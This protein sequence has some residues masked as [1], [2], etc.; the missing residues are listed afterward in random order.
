MPAPPAPWNAN[1]ATPKPA[2]S[3]GY[4]PESFKVDKPQTVQGQVTDII[5]KD[6][7][8]MQQAKT[9]AAQYANAR[10]LINSSMAAGAAQGAV[11]EAALPIAQQDASTYNNAMT[12]T[13]NAE[14][15]ARNFDAAGRNAASGQNAQLGTSVHLANQD[16][17]NKSLEAAFNAQTNYGLA[18]LDAN[19]KVALQHLD[20]ANKITLMNLENANRQSLQANQ[21]AASMFNQ[22]VTAIANISQ[23]PNLSPAAKDAAINSQLSLLSEGLRQQGNVAR[24]DLGSY[25]QQGSVGT[26]GD[27]VNFSNLPLMGSVPTGGRRDEVGHVFN[28]DGTPVTDYRGPVG[29]P[30]NNAGGGSQGGDGSQTPRPIAPTGTVTNPSAPPNQNS[31]TIQPVNP[32]NWKPGMPPP[33]GYKLTNRGQLVKAYPMLTLERTMT[34][35]PLTVDEIYLCVDYGYQFH[36]EKQ[37]PGDFNAEV[38]MRN[39]TIFMNSGLGAILG[40]WNGDELVGGLG[41]YLSPDITTGQMTANEFF[42]FVRE[43]ERKGSWPLRLVHA[44]KA[45]GKAHG[46]VRFRM[47]HLL[48]PNESVA[49]VRLAYFYRRLGMRPI[50]VGYEGEL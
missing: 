27:P 40:L 2:D 6:S 34:I 50:E 32:A 41:C 43:G 38:F 3:F 8:L 46:A 25:F 26:I 49:T 39:W 35:R 12:N 47:V 11:M 36:K 13:T 5:D 23:N 48:M 14:N 30:V 4:T 18:A 16:A 1:N 44:Y 24:L 9:R 31:G 20:N 37:V 22:V 15:A 7:P 33:P 19:T 10:G 45:W 42:W 17:A 21:D 29:Q 28:A